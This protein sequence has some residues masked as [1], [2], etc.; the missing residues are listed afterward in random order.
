MLEE[1]I[2]S[3]VKILSFEIGERN[4]IYKYSNL[5]A[6]ADYVKKEF[7]SYGYLPQEQIY[8]VDNKKYRN[9][10]ATKEGKSKRLIIV[11]AHYDSALGSPGADDNASGVAGILELARLLFHFETKKT[12]KFI[13]FTNEEPPWFMT[14]N[15]GSFVYANEAKKNREDIE[16]VLCFE[17][18]GYY[19]DSKRL[20]V[21]QFGSLTN[22]F[23]SATI[24]HVF[25]FFASY[26][27]ITSAFIKLE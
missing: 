26:L 14:S 4:G 5:Q 11:C 7:E 21:R 3:H 17:S 24:Y 22:N 10:I 27:F 25:Y 16:G 20:F 12:L 23:K 19:S 6:A 13:A 2:K 1:R 15:M 18:I 8:E 9:I